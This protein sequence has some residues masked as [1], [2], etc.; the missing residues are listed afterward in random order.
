MGIEITIVNEQEVINIDQSML[1]KL[2]SVL[3]EAAKHEEVEEGEV[4]VT[5]VTNEEI[6][7]L[8]KEY[9]NIDRPT[10]VLSF[11]MLET[12]ED[13]DPVDNP[14][15]PLM[16]GDIIIS[17]EKMVEQAQDYGHSEERELCFLAVHGF[18]HLI[19]YDHETEEDEKKMF[20]TQEQILQNV[21]VTR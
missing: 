17:A 19:G 3:H 4:S 2:T 20:E 18:L 5:I 15:A 10:D 11:A 12:I 13:E 9:R 8:N 16:L 14:E 7:Q 6:H 1:D 21:G